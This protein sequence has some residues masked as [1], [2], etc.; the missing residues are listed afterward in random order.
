MWVTCHNTGWMFYSTP[1]L[2]WFLGPQSSDMNS[3]HELKC[4]QLSF[5][6]SLCSVKWNRLNLGVEMV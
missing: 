1:P 3:E 2:F 6:T 5:I 4:G